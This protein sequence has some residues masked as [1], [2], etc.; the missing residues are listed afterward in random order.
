MTGNL[1][2]LDSAADDLDYMHARF[3]NPQTG[4]FLRV[5]PK[6]RYSPTTLPQRWNRYAYAIGNPLKYLDPDGRDLVLA[7]DSKALRNFLVRSLQRPSFRE[8]AIQIANDSTFTVTVRDARLTS[9]AEVARQRRQG[10]NPRIT[11][12]TTARDVVVVDGVARARGADVR[13]DTRMVSREHPDRTG[14]V[15]TTHEIAGHANDI[16]KGAPHAEMEAAHDAVEQLGYDVKNEPPDI[17]RKEAEKLL[18]EL[19]NPPPE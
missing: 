19:L 13:I 11:F 18:Q 16:R 17:T 7:S 8:V 1:V 6:N 15:T 9:P 3:Y 5:D 10:E 14:V 4:R 12:G 2:N